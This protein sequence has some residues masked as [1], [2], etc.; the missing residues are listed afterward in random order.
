VDPFPTHA[1]R[2][3]ALVTDPAPA[4]PRLLI[5]VRGGGGAARRIDFDQHEVT[6]G[7]DASA[8]VLL[9]DPGV[10]PAQLRFVADPDRRQIVV[11]PLPGADAAL[12]GAPL[13]RPT[14]LPARARITTG[15]HEL[16]AT[17]AW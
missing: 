10:A 7:R 11:Y 16:T 5:A 8:D 4:A 3:A 12:N 2:Y 14:P 17:A 9:D 6:V 13:T 15:D 1:P